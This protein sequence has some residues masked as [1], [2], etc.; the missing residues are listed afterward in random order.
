MGEILT[1]RA[2]KIRLFWAIA[3]AILP[4]HTFAKSNPLDVPIHVST[5]AE[6]W[7]RREALCG[8]LSQQEGIDFSFALQRV[9]VHCNSAV[10]IGLSGQEGEAL[11][12]GLINNHTP[13]QII[14]IAAALALAESA[15]VTDPHLTAVDGRTG[16]A[17]SAD[18]SYLLHAKSE[19]LNFVRGYAKD[20]DLE[21]GECQKG[22]ELTVDKS[23]LEAEKYRHGEKTSIGI[24]GRRLS[25]DQPGKYRR[26]LFG[27]PGTAGSF[28]K[29]PRCRLDAGDDQR[30]QRVAGGET[31]DG[32]TRDGQPM[33]Q[34]FPAG[35]RGT[36]GRLRASVVN[37]QLVPLLRFLQSI[38]NE[39]APE[40]RGKLRAEISLGYWDRAAKDAILYLKATNLH[41]GISDGFDESITDSTIA[42]NSGVGSGSPS[43][44]GGAVYPGV[45]AA[46]GLFPWVKG[47]LY[48]NVYSGKENGPGL[49]GYDTDVASSLRGVTLLSVDIDTRLPSQ[50]WSDFFSAAL[51]SQKFT[52]ILWTQHGGISGPV[53]GGLATLFMN[54]ISSALSPFLASGGSVVLRQC[55]GTFNDGFVDTVKSNFGGAPIYFAGSSLLSV[56]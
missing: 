43:N 52:G 6:L 24:S 26:D 45:D 55:Y 28:E 1:N 42:P 17:E 49:V 47:G 18:R 4:M 21:K 38:I 14:L 23:V 5:R 11:F 16:H 15:P 8:A 7:D 50:S 2:M 40:L 25:C 56:E 37:G 53:D 9:S 33:R 46:H 54:Q 3:F 51:G 32:T 35:K 29:S 31:E 44:G 19:G 30:Q 20:G 22:H 13:R 36:D 27:K 34:A 41:S 39:H 10:R 12:V 48:V